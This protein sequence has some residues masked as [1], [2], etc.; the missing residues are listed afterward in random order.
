MPLPNQIPV[1][2][3]PF[4]R[5]VAAFIAGIIAEWYFNVQVSTIIIF[6]SSSLGFACSYS[7]L[8]SS[9]KFLFEWLRGVFILLLFVAAGM[10]TTWQ[11]NVRHDKNW[12][13][14]IYSSNSNLLVTIKEPLIEKANSYKAVAEINAAYVNKRWLTTTGNILM[15]FKKDSVFWR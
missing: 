7:I 11:Q 12:Y 13:G 10:M 6:A 14:N 5:L 4:I 9:K 3:Y 8:S 1:K 15:Y 2:N